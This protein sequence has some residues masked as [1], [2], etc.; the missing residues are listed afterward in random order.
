LSVVLRC[1]GALRWPHAKLAHA[2]Q[3]SIV[4]GWASLSS[5]DHTALRQILY[6]DKYLHNLLAVERHLLRRRA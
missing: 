1:F 2:D 5:C 6:F 4:P 3:G